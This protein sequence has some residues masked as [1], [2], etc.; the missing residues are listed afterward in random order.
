MHLLPRNNLA[1]DKKLPETFCRG[2]GPMNASGST[3]ADTCHPQPAD[4]APPPSSS[5]ACA[6]SNCRWS[7][8]RRTSLLPA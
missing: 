5:A 4:D 3:A 7:T 6:T 2:C 1:A 8:R